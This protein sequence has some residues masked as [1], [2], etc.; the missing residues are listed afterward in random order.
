MR[1]VLAILVSFAF[2]ALAHA[3][4]QAAITQYNQ[5]SSNGS[6]IERISAAK[7][8]G[9]AVMADPSDAD[10]S[11]LAHEAAWTLCS[12]GNCAEAASI[13]Q[14]ALTLPD[15]ETGV[16]IPQRQLLSSYADW[17]LKDASRTRKA[18]DAALLAIKNTPPTALSVTA[19]KKRA[20]RDSLKG[21]WRSL[22]NT[23]TLGAEHL[24]PIKDLVGP[25][26]AEF[27]QAAITAAFNTYQDVEQLYLQ[28]HLEGEL[29][30]MDFEAVSNKQQMID[31]YWRASTW[32]MAMA[33]YFGSGGSKQKPKSGRVDDI[34]AGYGVNKPVPYDAI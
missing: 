24:S 13:A 17:A 7:A 28:A 26:W 15:T 25:L 19:F 18:L 23:A 30:A 20:E 2:H 32:R 6:D 9:A 5:A 4:V 3:D 8:L 34:L 21:D 12:L 31:A 33:A 11:L 14:F 1:L 29:R 22:K 27:R 16:T 10:A